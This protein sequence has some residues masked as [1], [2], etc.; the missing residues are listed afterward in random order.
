MNFGAMIFATES[1]IDPVELG[2]RLEDAGFESLFLPEHTHIPTSRESPFPGGG[3]LPREYSCTYDPFLTLTAVSA[4]T[5]RLVLGTGVCLLNQRDPIVTA[6]QVATL[7]HLCGG[8]FVF[9]VGAGW[10]AEEMRN[11]GTDPRLKWK[12]LR[13]RVEAMKAIWSNDE[14][15]YHGELVD[16]DPIWQ[17]PKPLQRPHP[18]IL[19]GSSTEAALP[20]VARYADGWMPSGLGGISDFSPYITRMNQ[21][22]EEVGRP[23]PPVSIYGAAADADSVERNAA[24]GVERMIF[25]LPSAPAEEIVPLL[26]RWRPLIQAFGDHS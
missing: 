3:E 8:R 15:S 12:T 19:L 1:S 6:K 20:R 26:E 4:A 24:A 9:G 25:R 17:W 2:K 13:E 5:E 23:P 18:P 11:H 21:L 22:C 7:D 14:A 16:F 10:N